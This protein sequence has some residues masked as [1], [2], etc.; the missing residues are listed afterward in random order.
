MKVKD[1]EAMICHSAMHMHLLADR[2]FGSYYSSSP[3][4]AALAFCCAL[5]LTSLMRVSQSTWDWLPKA[6]QECCCNIAPNETLKA[7]RKKN[8]VMPET[9]ELC[10]AIIIN[11]LVIYNDE[12]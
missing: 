8:M 9:F 6:E 12:I 1:V 11:Y 2:P 5:R 10:T 3:L 7:Q 4:V